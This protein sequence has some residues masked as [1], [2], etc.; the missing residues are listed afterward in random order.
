MNINF[1]ADRPTRST[2]SGIAAPKPHYMAVMEILKYQHASA[3]P[4]FTIKTQCVNLNALIYCCEKFE[5]CSLNGLRIIVAGNL[6]I[7]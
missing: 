1:Y 4:S 5:L 7:I 6:K 3:N 2:V